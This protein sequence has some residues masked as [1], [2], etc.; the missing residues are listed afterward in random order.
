MKARLLALRKIDPKTGCWVSRRTPKSAHYGTIRINGKQ[1]RRSRAAAAAFLG[2]DLGSPLLVLHRCDNPPC[3]NPYH[4]FVGTAK[5]NAMDAK[6]KGRLRG[7][8][9]KRR[10]PMIPGLLAHLNAILSRYNVSQ[11]D[12]ARDI[13]MNEATLS[14]ILSGKQ[15]P[16][17]MTKRAIER[18]LDEHQA[19]YPLRRGV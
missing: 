16:Q 10:E 2:F 12:I 7:A 5:D 9:R 13:G 3:F 18:W 4:L 14:R 8:P 15:D 17:I 6:Q 19:D 1:V 11:R